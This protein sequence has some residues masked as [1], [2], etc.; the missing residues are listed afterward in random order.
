MDRLAEYGVYL[1]LIDFVTGEGI[2][3][4]CASPPFGTDSRFRK[5]LLPRRPTSDSERGLRDEVDLTA[6]DSSSLLLVEC[7]PT[8]RDS[9]T[10]LNALGET[11]EAKLLR[12]RRSL[13]LPQLCEL[14]QR[15]TGLSLPVLGSMALVLAVGVINVDIP[16]SMTVME[17]TQRAVRIYPVAPLD[18]RWKTPAGTSVILPI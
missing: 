9:L 16:K 17:V 18:A 8:L 10:T 15:G 2:R 6:H 7:K 11:D 4:V 12:L 5:C 3:I 1:R 13:E 14:L